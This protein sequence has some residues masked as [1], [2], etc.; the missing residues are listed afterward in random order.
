MLAIS[1]NSMRWRTGQL[2]LSPI[3]ARTRQACRSIRAGRL[4]NVKALSLKLSP[5][6]CNFRG[7][8]APVDAFRPVRC[9]LHADHLC[10]GETKLLVYLPVRRVLRVGLGLRLSSGRVAVRTGGSG[11]VR[12]GAAPVVDGSRAQRRCDGIF[13]A[14]CWLINL[15]TSRYQHLINVA[16]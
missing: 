16:P 11:V 2:A 3:F 13:G 4:C 10:A 7:V 15:S 14:R 5:V 6:G 1:Q 9:E 12:G 8:C